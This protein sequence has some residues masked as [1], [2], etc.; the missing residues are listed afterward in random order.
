MTLEYVNFFA[1]GSLVGINL[2]ASNER[3][4]R[5]VSGQTGEPARVADSASERTVPYSAL[6]SIADQFTLLILGFYSIVIY[7]H[8]FVVHLHED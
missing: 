6:S 1:L 8:I 4:V 7:I 5:A 2:Q 3:F